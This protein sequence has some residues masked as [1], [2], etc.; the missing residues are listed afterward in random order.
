MNLK[1]FDVKL[2]KFELKCQASEILLDN[3]SILFGYTNRI[4]AYVYDNALKCSRSFKTINSLIFPE[5]KGI[6]TDERNYRGEIF[7]QRNG[8]CYF[9]V[10]NR[11][12]YS[13]IT[14]FYVQA[15]E[16][17]NGL[18]K[19]AM[20]KTRELKALHLDQEKQEINRGELTTKQVKQ[21]RLHLDNET[22][23]DIPF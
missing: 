10:T 7:R 3:H 14:N 2:P 4:P 11:L 20:I 8:R 12:P 18:K 5:G 21:Y 6:Y 23:V 22:S 1:Q 16:C 9:K 17:L 15:Q 13:K 19:L